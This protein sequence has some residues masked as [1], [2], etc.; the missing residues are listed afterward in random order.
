MIATYVNCL[1]VIVGS[2]LGLTFRASVNERFQEV[3]YTGV[4]MV[5]LVIGII[6]TIET[7]RILYVALAVVIGGILGEWWNIEGGILKFGSFVQRKFEKKSDDEGG[8]AHGFLNASILFCVGAMTIVGS[9][10]AGVDGQYDIILTKSVMDG[11]M[12]ILLA[13]VMGPGVIFSVLTILIYQGGLTLVSVA[14]SP[15]IGDL[16]LSEI[17]GAGGVL[18]IMIGLSL[19]KIKKIKTGNYLPA[20]FLV[21]A[22]TL[23]EPIVV[24]LIGSS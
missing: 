22:A 2:V 20:L 19:L 15:W 10:R 3:V 5:S 14:L 16:V 17:S 21:L 8:F 9:F 24:E 23:L 11:S 12:A 13:A 18:I 4:G 1:A 6:M 7:T